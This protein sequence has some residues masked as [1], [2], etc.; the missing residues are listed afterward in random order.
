MGHAHYFTCLF[1]GLRQFVLQP[2][3]SL[4]APLRACVRAAPQ[5]VM[6]CQWSGTLTRCLSDMLLP[7]HLFLLG[8]NS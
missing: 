5:R 7:A 4:L 1:S 2:P 3:R 6:P 8:P